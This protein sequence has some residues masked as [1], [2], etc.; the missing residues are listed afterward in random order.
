MKANFTVEFMAA[1][2]TAESGDEDKIY[3]AVEECRHLNINILPPDVNESF[4]NF[5]V[6]DE[7]N[8][9]FGLNAIKNLGSDV[10][11]KIIETRNG[12]QV[13]REEAKETVSK[14]QL[15][16]DSLTTDNLP[17]FSSLEDFLISCYT[18]N[19]NK[20]SWEA[21]AKSGALDKFGERGQLLANTELVLDFLRENFKVKEEGQNSLFGKSMQ[22]GKLKLKPAPEATKEEKLVWEKEHLGMYVSSHPLDNYK[23]V[24]TNFTPI[25]NL[26]EDMFDTTVTLGGIISKLKRTLTR[27]NDPMAFFT[28]EDTA[29][30]IEVL[31][32]PKVMMAALPYLETEKIIQVTGRLSDK[33]GDFK[34]IAEE[35]KDLPNDELY[36]MAL[37]E[38]EKSQQVVIYMQDANNAQV[39]NQIKDVIINYPGNAQV[40]LHLGTG[41][42][43]KKI[44]TKT[45]VR[46]TGDLISAL[47]QFPQITMVSDK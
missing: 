27:K 22:I 38:M 16:T 37:S 8:I 11:A 14:D 18:K 24:L 41:A 33:D 2:M 32:F 15:T 1:L 21:L 3:A 40:Y 23:V 13:A 43:T 10:I 29:A 12:R 17:L 4:D 28:L 39:L 25:K 6:V 42:A 5:T 20:K 7:H 9:R 47:K 26:T 46:I 36:N 19:L 31:V 34:L 35:I 44:K 30:S 45:Q